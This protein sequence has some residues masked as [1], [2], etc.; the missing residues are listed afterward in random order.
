LRSGGRGQR[1]ERT[2]PLNPKGRFRRDRG[3]AFNITFT[4]RL[5]DQF[6]PGFSRGG[7]GRVHCRGYRIR[8][9]N[10]DGRNGV[11]WPFGHGAFKACGRKKRSPHG[12]PFWEAGLSDVAGAGLHVP[13]ARP[14]GFWKEN[15]SWDVTPA[16]KGRGFAPKLFCNRWTG[17]YRWLVSVPSGG[18]SPAGSSQE[19][20]GRE[21]DRGNSKARRRVCPNDLGGRLRRRDRRVPSGPRE[22]YRETTV[23]PRGFSGGASRGDEELHDR[24]RDA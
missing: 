5:F 10:R 18:V 22:S 17:P 19:H 16:K 4:G 8:D 21:T 2:R 6:P 9:C 7:A 12:D 1:A 24:L 23:G 15:S 3:G 20:G 11:V 14:D 13:F